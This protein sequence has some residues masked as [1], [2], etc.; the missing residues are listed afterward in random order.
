[1]RSTAIWG[2]HSIQCS[3]PS[4]SPLKMVPSVFTSRPFAQTLKQK[5]V[6]EGH[7]YIRDIIIILGSWEAGS[8]YWNDNCV[9]DE[10]LKPADDCYFRATGPDTLESSVMSLPYLLG[11]DQWCDLTE[12]RLH[13]SDIPTKHNT[14]CGGQSVFEVVRQSQDFE[15]YEPLN[16][17]FIEPD[18]TIL[19]PSSMRKQPFTF[20]LDY[21]KSMETQPE[22]VTPNQK[23]IE[24]LKQGI[25]RF[26]EVDVDLGLG[27]PLGVVSFSSV[28]DSKIN[29]E[30]IFVNDTESRDK[31]V[32]TVLGLDCFQ[33]TCLHTGIRQGLRALKDYGLETGGTAILVSG[34]AQDCGE[35]NEDWLETIIDE[36]MAQN[37][38]FC[39]IAFSGDADAKLEELAHR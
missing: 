12:E 2:I 18:F 10:N 13:H 21:S 4:R 1:M 14:M 15:G 30:I 16:T 27:L 37:V 28:E 19:R 5:V 22:R 35:E 11:N 31:I 9:F 38:R 26:M 17:D 32:D 24:R 7:Y 25:K 6:F 20:I 3:T 33:N 29:Q 23:R 39:T 8:D 36:V 34:G